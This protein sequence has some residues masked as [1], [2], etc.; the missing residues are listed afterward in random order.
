MNRLDS[1]LPLIVDNVQVTGSERTKSSFIESELKPI[2]AQNLP[3]HQFKCELDN[4]IHRLKDKGLYSYVNVDLNIKNVDENQCFHTD[5]KISLKEKRIPYLKFETYVK[6]KSTSAVAN[7]VGCEVVGALRNPLGYGDMYKLSYSTNSSGGLK[8]YQL[9]SHF[10][11]FYAST[12]ESSH[13]SKNLDIT[14][15]SAE[16]DNSY[17]LKYKQNVKSLVADITSAIS[18]TN[19]HKYGILNAHPTSDHKYQVEMT[20]RDEIPT[21][22]LGSSVLSTSVVNVRNASNGNNHVFKYP[23]AKVLSQLFPSTKLS[24]KHVYTVV[25]TRDSVSKPSKGSFLQSNFEFATPLGT[26]QYLKTEL[27]T[28]YHQ[29]FGPSLYGQRPVLSV[30]G[31]LGL[32]TPLRWIQYKV[33]NNFKNRFIKPSSLNTSTSA[34]ILSN[35]VDIKYNSLDSSNGNSL[36]FV[37]MSDRYHLGGPFSMRGFQ[38][39]G[40]GYQGSDVTSHADSLKNSTVGKSGYN[41]S[42]L[43]GSNS[44]AIDEDGASLGGVSKCTLLASLSVPLPV[45]SL[46]RTGATAFGFVNFGGVGSPSIYDFNHRHGVAS[47]DNEKPLLFGA[48]RMSL[49]CGVAVPLGSAARLE[50]TYALPV[51]RASTDVTK[52]FQIGVGMTVN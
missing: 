41:L 34:D 24:L 32:I 8:E 27:L 40:A 12:V 16:D 11:H 20:A 44:G 15:R 39:Y 38:L 25:D 21:S 19:S 47:I 7:E 35:I 45:E 37:H 26:A 51:L 9:S 36:N 4:A 14:L 10:P 29:S 49:G 17:F 30:S 42:Q 18:F 22:Y 43:T 3:L 6:A 5:M 28:Q 50:L 1:N 33:T 2:L 52:P 48:M 23:N 46:A 13:N 31:S